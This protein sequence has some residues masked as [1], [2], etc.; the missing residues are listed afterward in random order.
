MRGARGRVEHL[1][2]RVAGEHHAATPVRLLTYVASGSVVWQALYHPPDIAGRSGVESLLKRAQRIG[3]RHGR[4]R[5]SS[6]AL[7]SCP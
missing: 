1:L 7:A 2:Q 4:R 3:E 5:C 6:R